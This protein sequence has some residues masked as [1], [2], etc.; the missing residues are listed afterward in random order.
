MGYATLIVAFG[1]KAYNLLIKFSFVEA[2]IYNDPLGVLTYVTAIMFKLGSRLF[3]FHDL[4]SGTFP[5][6]RSPP[7]SPFVQFGKKDPQRAIVL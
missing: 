4:E 6:N 7:H 5:C 1:I 3:S 2:G